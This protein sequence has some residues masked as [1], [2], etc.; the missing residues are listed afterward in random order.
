MNRALNYSIAENLSKGE[1]VNEWIVCRLD[2][3]ADIVDCEHKTAPIEENTEFYSIRTSNILNGKI[4]FQG[5]NRVSFETYQEWTKR[6]IPK[7]GDI[8]LAREAP[9]GEVGMVKKDRKVC[10]GQRTVLL[11]VNNE[12]VHNHYLLYYLVNP[13]IKFELISRSTGSVVSHLNMKDI[14]AF[15]ISL[16]PY[17]EQKAI[18]AVLSSLDDKIDLLHRQNQTL[19]AMAETL[20]RQWFVVEAQEDWDEGTLDDLVEFNYGKTLRDHERSGH[21]FPVYGSSGIVGY[22]H[23]YLVKAPGIITGRKG[24]L[25]VI[26]YSFKNFFPIDTTFYITSKTESDGLFFEYF[27]LKTLN[28]AEMNSDSAV[29]GLNRNLAHGMQLTIP[30]MQ[31]IKDFNQR[32]KPFFNKLSINQSHIYTLETLRDTLLPK[33]MSGE[34][35]VNYG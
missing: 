17:P 19:E 11:S 10:L 9:V 6:A 21:G 34:V 24:T 32:I 8:I 29:P 16:P 7:E 13:A 14:R 25:G 31:L 27:L 30:P 1:V 22:H 18:A 20:F 4:D 15:E 35:R 28:L 3:V 12:N 33:L 26:N 2:E 23:E 5:S